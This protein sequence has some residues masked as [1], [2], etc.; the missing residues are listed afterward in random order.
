MIITALFDIKRE[1]TGDGRTVKQY[2][3]WFATTLQV[4]CDM[5]IYTES[6]FEDFVVKNRKNIP[7]KTEIVVQKLEDIPFYHNRETMLSILT[8]PIYKFK[9]KDPG[10][11][12]CFLPEYNLIQYSKFGWL[13]RTAE[14]NLDHDFFMWMDAGCSRFFL[15]TDLSKQWPNTNALR[16]NKFIIQR[17]A[18]F[19]KLWPNMKPEQYMWE[20]QCVLV[21]TLFGGGREVIYKMKDMIDHVCQNI[22]F[23]NNCLNNEQF[24]ITIAAKMNTDL[25][26][27]RKQCLDGEEEGSSHLP[28]FKALSFDY[29]SNNNE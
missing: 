15:D 14:N 12:E 16:K 19:T 27:I 11:I 23:G 9:M 20:S 7:H 1:K 13:K 22:F 28:L 3:E 29:Q 10:R 4:K 25:F 21:G 26:D 8:S 18:F 24:A 6:K 5:T 17:N 2:L